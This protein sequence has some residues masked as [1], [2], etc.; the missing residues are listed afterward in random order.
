MGFLRGIWLTDVSLFLHLLQE[1]SYFHHA[2]EK[3]RTFIPKFR[4][5][6]THLARSLCASWPSISSELTLAP[7]ESRVSDRSD[8]WIFCT[9]A[10]SIQSQIFIVIFRN[11]GIHPWFFWVCWILIILRTRAWQPINLNWQRECFKFP[12]QLY[13]YS[14]VTK[15]YCQ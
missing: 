6:L 9:G 12:L 11:L 8:G 14:N 4:V 15:T 13:M 10:L 1:A 2:G 3:K 7:V 5:V